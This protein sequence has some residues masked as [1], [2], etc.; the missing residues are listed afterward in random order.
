MKTANIRDVNKSEKRERSLRFLK[1]LICV[2]KCVSCGEVLDIGRLDDGGYVLCDKCRVYWEKE[3]I[4][5][6][7]LCLRDYS[8]C[9]CPTEILA[10]SGCG[11]LISLA[12]YESG[13]TGVVNKAIF[14]IKNEY[15][16]E[17]TD[18]LA[19]Q[20]CYR[21]FSLVYEIGIDNIIVTYAPRTNKAKRKNG[22]DQSELLAKR[23]AVHLGAKYS[24][25]ICRSRGI[26]SSREQKELDKNERAQNASA[27]F[28][29]TSRIEDVRGKCVILVDDVATTGA[30]LGACTKLLKDSGALSVMCITVARTV[31][32]TEK[33]RIYKA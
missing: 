1:A 24:K 31:P 30:T 5:R 25:L 16:S 21:I 20:L 28:K 14:R 18:F 17:L 19:K 32:K 29:P 3:R 8:E 13:G 27:S 12:P 33:L 4:K 7:P 15:D 22:H 26:A 11:V 23:L 2:P 9:T 10:S 6:C